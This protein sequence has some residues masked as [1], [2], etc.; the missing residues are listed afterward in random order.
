[1][2]PSVF[3]RA[4]EQRTMAENEDPSTI[5]AGQVASIIAATPR[6]STWKPQ[7]PMDLRIVRRRQ[8]RSIDDLGPEERIQLAALL[9]PEPLEKVLAPNYLVE[10]YPLDIEVAEVVDERN[11]V[12]YR[13]YG[14]NYGAGFLMAATGLE[15]V[16]L[17]YQH[18]LEHWNVDQREVF[19][20]MDR[21]YSRG[22]HGFQQP[23]KF[24]WW[25]ERCWDEVKDEPRGTVGSEPWIREHLA[26]SSS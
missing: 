8:P 22:D 12:R 14:W 3:W 19:W 7:H 16:A 5:Y 25:E 1:M 15:V 21:A 23:L 4:L 6:A 18:D 20:A 13:L 26:K 24:C 9:A 2:L 11:A 17:A 10:D